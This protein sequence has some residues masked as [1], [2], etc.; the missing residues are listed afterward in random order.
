MGKAI[1]YAVMGLI[2]IG[3][4]IGFGVAIKLLV[5]MFLGKRKKKETHA[6]PLSH[7]SGCRCSLCTGPGAHGVHKHY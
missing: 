4:L 6:E 3:L 7:T 1:V 5:V 2:T